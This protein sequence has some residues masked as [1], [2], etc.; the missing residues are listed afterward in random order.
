MPLY[1]QESE[2]DAREIN[3]EESLIFPSAEEG[4]AGAQE[5]QNTAA[6]GI[7]DIVQM[8]LVLALVAAAIYGVII[9]LKKASKKGFHENNLIQVVS[10]APLVG[11]RA[12]H[13]VQIGNQY[14]LI[15]SADEQISLISE[16]TD[17][18]SLDQIRLTSSQEAPGGQSSN[19]MEMLQG[20]F[21]GTQKKKEK[22]NE[23]DFQISTD[24]M[25]EQRDRLKRL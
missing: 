4:E 24:F 3:D 14:F 7:W 2:G 1:T 15:G 9:F 18:E 23:G 16:I 22:Q 17:K 12:L 8:F 11:Q 6:V 13:L 20:M 10:S 25:K 19:F 5:G 21:A